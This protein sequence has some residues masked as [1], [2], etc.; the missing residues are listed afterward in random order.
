VPAVRNPIVGEAWKRGPV[1]LEVCG[2]IHEWYG[3]GIDLDRIFEKGLE[4]HLSGLN[5]KSK[6]VP[7]VWRPRF[8]E[9]LKKIGYRFV[10]REMS[11]ASER[12]AGEPL[13]FR[14]RWENIGVAPIYHAWPLA[15]RLR[16]RADHVVAQWTSHADLKQWLP[17]P[18]LQ[19]VDELIVPKTIRSG[20]YFI[21]VAIL[22]EDGRSPH[23]DQAIEGKRTDRWYSLSNVKIR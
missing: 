10:L 2:Y 14:S 4:W 16:S 5:A 17:G 6:P 12:Q 18:S 11:H 15:Y 20:T 22:S 8:D 3:R 13:I 7:A 21:D 19:I 23:V 9:F 1:Q